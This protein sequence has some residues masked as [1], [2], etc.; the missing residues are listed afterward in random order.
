MHVPH[1]IDP[2]TEQTVIKDSPSFAVVN[3]KSSYRMQIDKG[4]RLTAALGIKNLLDAY[5]S[6]LDRGAEKDAGYIYGPLLPQTFTFSLQIDR[7]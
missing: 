1:V 6:D 4:W 3:W 7:N 2:Q 5:Q